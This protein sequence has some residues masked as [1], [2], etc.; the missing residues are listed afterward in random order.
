MDYAIL[1]H[2][3]LSNFPLNVEIKPKLHSIS[4]DTWR[5][6]CLGLATL[7]YPVVPPMTFSHLYFISVKLPDISRSTLSIFA[8][9]HIS[10]SCNFLPLS[11]G[12]S[13]ENLHS[14]FKT[15]VKTYV[16]Y[17]LQS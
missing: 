11:T 13:L 8:F 4:Y 14:I 3:N 10:Y 17:S 9:T 15:K 7:T 1:L 6:A 5:G 12:L 16:P 2:M